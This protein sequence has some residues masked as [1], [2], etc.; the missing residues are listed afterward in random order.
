MEEWFKRVSQKL[1]ENSQRT[2]EGCLV[3]LKGPSPETHRYG[4]VRTKLPVLGSKSQVFYVHRLSYMVAHRLL[5]LPPD[6]EVS[7][8]C[9]SARCVEAGH[10][11][12][13]SHSTNQDRV[14]CHLQGM[15]TKSHNPHCV[16]IQ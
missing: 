7:H 8:L 6:L 16:I 12:L 9:H 3:W 14:T 15:C 2:P 4:R 10:L 11:C 1:T 5:E 13:E